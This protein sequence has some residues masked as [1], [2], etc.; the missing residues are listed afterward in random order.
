MPMPLDL[1]LQSMRRHWREG[2]IDE[3]VTLAKAAA[4]Y[5]HARAGAGRGAATLAAMEDDQID[6]LCRRSLAGTPPA[7]S[8]KE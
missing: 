1:I 6:E 2:R 4:P 5:L 3:A 8:D 7:S